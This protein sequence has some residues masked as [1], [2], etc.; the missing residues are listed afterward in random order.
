[1]FFNPTIKLLTAAIKA[2]AY[3]RKKA[4]RRKILYERI[5]VKLSIC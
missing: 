3:L 1:M 5:K 2:Q 4:W